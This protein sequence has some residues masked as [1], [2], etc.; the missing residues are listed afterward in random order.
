MPFLTIHQSKGLEFPVVV[1]GSL[2]RAEREAPVVE[3]AVRNLLNK[4]GEPLEWIDK[5]DTMRIFYVGLSRA[6]NLLILPRYTHAKA[7]EAEFKEI[8]EE[9]RLPLVSDL[10]PG[11]IPAAER[12]FEELGKSYSYTGDYLL[13]KR[14]P[15]NYMI[16]RKYG[17]V[18]SRGQTMFFGRLVHETVEDLHHLV[19]MEK[20]E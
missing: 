15:R 11:T 8:L 10:D 19:M 14:C 13:Y 12:K 17:F 7:A 6:K 2:Y 3:C 9:E 4:E 1:L 5:F 16:Y 20:R 18:P